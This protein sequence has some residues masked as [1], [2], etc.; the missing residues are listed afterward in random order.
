LT[1]TERRVVEL[2]G[3][4]LANRAIATDLFVSRRTVESHVSAAYR[5]LEVTSRVEL[6]RLALGHGRHGPTSSNA[7]H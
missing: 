4:G 7:G 1:A 6:A 5:K 3:E 2:I